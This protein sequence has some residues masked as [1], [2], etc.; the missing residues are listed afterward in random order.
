MKLFTLTSDKLPT[1][2]GYYVVITENNKIETFSYS[3][4][5]NMFNA[6]DSNSE[7]DVNKFAI[8]VIAWCKIEDF[9]KEIG[10]EVE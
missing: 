3:S 4:R 9:M 1:E 10:Y 2:S 8:R 5:Y 7:D 6:Y